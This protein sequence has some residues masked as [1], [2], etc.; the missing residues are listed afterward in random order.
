MT[1]WRK[2]SHSGGSA[3]SD[4]VE[5]ARFPRAVGMRDSKNP[6]GPTFALSRE[7]FRALVRD[8]KAGDHD[9]P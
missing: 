5:L 1:N 8:V 2:S 6:D 9:A 3:T 7:I 4:C